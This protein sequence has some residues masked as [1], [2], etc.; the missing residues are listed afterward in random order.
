LQTLGSP[1]D[2]FVIPS[3]S[4]KKIVETGH[5]AGLSRVSLI[6]YSFSF[7][8]NKFSFAWNKLTKHKF[9]CGLIFVERIEHWTLLVVSIQ[10]RRVYYIDPLGAIQEKSQEIFHNWW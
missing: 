9:L 8:L 5:F 3:N 7:A 10:L 4:I 6:D 1:T 2:I